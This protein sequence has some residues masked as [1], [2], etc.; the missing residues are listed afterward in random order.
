MKNHQPLLTHFTVYAF[1]N[2]MKYFVT[3]RYLIPIFTFLTRR[4]LY[5]LFLSSLNYIGFDNGLTKGP[6]PAT[7]YVTWLFV[8][9]KIDQFEGKVKFDYITYFSDGRLQHFGWEMEQR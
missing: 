9:Q 6:K 5:D 2:L 4:I 1:K 8:T 3:D 7:W